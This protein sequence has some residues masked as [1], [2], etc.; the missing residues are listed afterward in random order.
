MKIERI[1]V[2]VFAVCCGMA[3]LSAAQNVLPSKL[4][5][6]VE[7]E[8]IVLRKGIT[9]GAP[10][11]TIQMIVREI[12]GVKNA[13]LELVASPFREM[14][15]GDIVDLSTITVKL[16][17]PQA[18]VEP[19]GLQ[20]I[21]A[22]IGGFLQAGTYLG[23]ITVHDTV[24]G[25]RR[26]IPVR[27]SVKDAWLMPGA[28]LFAAVLT[29]AGVNYWTKKGRRKN[30]LD[31]RLT[32]LQ[33]TLKLAGSDE[34]PILSD[35]LQFLEKAR[36]YTQ[37]FQFSRAEASIEAGK[38][39]LE[40][41]E[42]RKH[43]SEALR[44]TIQA[45][46]HDAREF[47]ESDPQNARLNGELIRLLPNVEHDLEGTEAIVKQLEMF[48]HAYRLARRDAFTAREKLAGSGEYVKKADQSKIEF[49]L[50]EIDRM[51]TNA[52]T[53]SAL[54]EANALLRKV[55]FELS[56]EKIND[57]IFRSQR[58]EKRLDLLREQVKRVTGT[59]MQRI[60]GN[61]QER[62]ESA[63]RD[64]RCEESEAALQELDHTLKL[65]EKM[66]DVEKRV[67]GKEPKMT[68]IRR[69]LRDAKALLE[70][71]SGM[72]SVLRAE[73]DVTQAVEMLDGRREQYEPFAAQDE[74]AVH[75]DAH[76]PAPD[77]D[78]AFGEGASTQL[79]PIRRED[80]EQRVN[81][82]LDEAARYPRLLPK[83]ERW[84]AVCDKLV[85]FEELAD[86][87]E[88]LQRIQEELSLYTRILA[89]RA[90]AEE[91]RARAAL[92]LTEQAHQ[93]LLMESGEDRG[94][95]HRAEV[96]ADAAN[97]LLDEQ[98]G[99]RDIESVLAQ[100]GSPKLATQFVTYGTLASYFVIATTLG[101]QILYAP[102][103]DFGA[104]SFEH[105]FS[106][107]LWAFGLEGAKMTA[108]NVYEA[109]FKKEG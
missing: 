48:L 20:R 81:L 54:D 96:L 37:E 41:Y 91:Q 62:A 9:V 74:R 8:E 4:Q 78:A 2:I 93:L 92:Q 14:N 109:Y 21:E 52:E 13:R 46:L 25:E 103:P 34:N 70:N 64:N 99:E 105:Y 94:A 28:V 80:L 38:Q 100:I 3:R 65:V 89:I 23:A 108:T 26:E 87:T 22:T 31:L 42:Q 63:L 24:S 58:I 36:A 18:A 11:R 90:M 10:D 45:L 32:E 73:H 29:A 49:L 86:L 12:S 71:A 75:A 72:E 84:R 27:V 97:A 101:F 77:T 57:N 79:R 33:E 85:R 35:A 16:S 106:L 95:L 7:P 102:S 6:A 30:R 98:P 51:L 76:E 88:Y 83:I 55:A 104:L 67:K 15:S 5:I 69:I 40:A 47:G 82:L 60:V 66:K 1:F 17:Q 19:G 39:R 107:V 68:E 43:G 53:M 44:Q 56:P 59:Q 61:M 50:R